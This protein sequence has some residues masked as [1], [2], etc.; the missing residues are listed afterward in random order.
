MSQSVAN[1][2]V[3]DWSVANPQDVGLDASRIDRLVQS[4]RNKD[5]YED[6]HSILIVR[7]GRL[8]VEEY[9][10][11]WR[12]D[13]IQTLQSVTKSIASALIGIAIARGDIRDV[14]EHVY[15]F[16]PETEALLS[17]QPLRKKLR[18]EHLLTMRSGTDYHEDGASSPHY[19]LNRLRSDWDQFYL[20]RDMI[21][22]PGTAFQYDSGGVILL[23]SL[24]FE[25]YS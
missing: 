9:F 6:T 24:M 10:D 5:R 21:N 1:D 13:R 7:H 23:S 19:E 16:F 2:E 4:I 20:Q 11:G 15:D 18:L 22:E 14:G 3:N 8:V 12:A 17:D 25:Y